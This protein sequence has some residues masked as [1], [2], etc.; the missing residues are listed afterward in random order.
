MG[1]TDH[2][3]IVPLIQQRRL[4]FHLC[5]M[6]RR[7]KTLLHHGEASE[8]KS[9]RVDFLVRERIQKVSL[10]YYSLDMAPFDFCVFPNVKQTLLRVC[11]ESPDPA[12]KAFIALK[13]FLLQMVKFLL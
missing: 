13:R 9:D 6:T 7:R 5:P 10:L 1:K 4:V 3:A 12:V 8:H 11:Y 2:F